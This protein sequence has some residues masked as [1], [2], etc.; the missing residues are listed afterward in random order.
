MLVAMIDLFDQMGWYVYAAVFV[1]M[2]FGIANVLLM[3]VYERIREI[4]VLMAV[5][6]RPRRL[7]A[8]IF[9]ES[10]LLAGLGLVLGLVAAFATT[11][12][13]ADGIDLSSYSE[14]LNAYGIG[15]KIVPVIRSQ[16]VTTP[17][18]VALVTALLASLW[19]A[20]RVVRIR[21]AEAVRRV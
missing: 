10:M 21:P 18:I 11:W 15:T 16:D 9:A 14:G 6:M 2:A 19:P 3:A 8:M 13:L 1:A 12:A 17:L 4:G 7:V 20:L 5:G